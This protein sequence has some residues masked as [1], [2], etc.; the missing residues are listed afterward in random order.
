MAV[1]KARYKADKKAYSEAISTQG[2]LAERKRVS[3]LKI[4]NCKLD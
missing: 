3:K 4:N 2:V 1:E